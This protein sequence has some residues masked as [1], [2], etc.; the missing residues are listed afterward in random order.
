MTLL[1]LASFLGLSLMLLGYQKCQCSP[2]NKTPS[3]PS[4][5]EKEKRGGGEKTLPSYHRRLLITTS[6]ETE[7]ITNNL[8]DLLNISYEIIISYGTIK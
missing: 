5:G 8:K 3:P 4:L 1:L 7:K 2:V 6:F